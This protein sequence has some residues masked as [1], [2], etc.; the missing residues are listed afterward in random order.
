MHVGL[1]LTHVLLNTYDSSYYF[2]L[3]RQGS[4]HV[5]FEFLGEGGG[6]EG[7]DDGISGDLV[8]GP[9]LHCISCTLKNLFTFNFLW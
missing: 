9:A 1:T 6:G 8:H 5:R 7:V 4:E 2:L 3:Q